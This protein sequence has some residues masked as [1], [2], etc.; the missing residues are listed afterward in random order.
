MLSINEE[1]IEEKIDQS[2]FSI[3]IVK[4]MQKFN[5]NFV[6]PHSIRSARA[7]REESICILLEKM[8]FTSI[9]PCGMEH[10]SSTFGRL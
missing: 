1:Q 8:M 10:L 9:R 4:T 2:N 3:L 5:E 6:F 7:A